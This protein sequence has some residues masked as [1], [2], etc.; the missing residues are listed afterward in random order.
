MEPT[1][2]PV[3]ED[4]A[5]EVVTDEVVEAPVEA[6]VEAS[7]VLVEEPASVDGGVAP[8]PEPVAVTVSA[9]PGEEG[10]SLYNGVGTTLLAV[11]LGI[12]IVAG[13]QWSVSRIFSKEKNPHRALTQFVTMMVAI[14][15]G[16]YVSDMLIAGPHVQLLAEGERTAI[17]GFVKDT[18][19]MIF[20]YY[21]GTQSAASKDPE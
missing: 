3:P 15:V 18:A 20:A 4:A 5:P 12:V 6:P 11:L 17:L 21:F 7:E 8:P 19:L 10:F 9:S 2:T 13:V 1:S 14:M 16:V